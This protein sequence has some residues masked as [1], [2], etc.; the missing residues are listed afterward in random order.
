METRRLEYKPLSWVQRA[1]RNPN[2]HQL[3]AIAA[4]IRRHGFVEPVVVD[5]RTGFLIGGHGRVDVLQQMR[6]DAAERPAGIQTEAGDW[7]LPVILGWSSRSDAEAEALLVAMM[8][9]PKEPVEYPSVLAEILDGLAA[10]TELG[11]D[12]T[13]YSTADLD[14]LVADLAQN[15]ELGP[16][17]P[18]TEW[19]GMPDFESSNQQSKFSLTVHF[20]SQADADRFWTDLLQREIRGESVARRSVWWPEHDGFVGSD[21]GMQYVADG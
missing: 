15:P 1:P 9:L 7:L 11:L 20:P 19:E 8:R 17:D 4:S 2:G 3:P 13:G 21:T 12:G 18:R 5:E 6:D 16:T 14:L 10:S